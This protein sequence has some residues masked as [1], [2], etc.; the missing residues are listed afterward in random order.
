MQIT[1]Q[2]LIKVYSSSSVSQEVHAVKDVTLDIPSNSIFGIIGKSGAGKSTLVRLISLL[3]KPDKGQVL[4]DGVRVDSLEGKAL[5]QQRRRIGMIFQSFNLFSSRTAAKNVAYPLEICGV[6]GAEIKKRVAEL[7]DLVGLGDRADSPVSQLSGGQ[8]QRIAIARAL[9]NKPDILFCDEAT[10][11]LDPQTTRS[12]LDLIRQIQKKMHLTVVM[13]T[14]QMEV[15]RDACDYVAVLNEGEIA[16]QGSVEDIFTHPKTEITKD[17]LANL[18]P[19][20]QGFETKDCD[21]GIVRWSNDGGKYIFRFVGE[22]TGEPLLSKAT[23]LYGVE[24]NIRA[25][26][27][28]HISSGDVGTLIADINGDSSE[29]TAAIKYLGAQGVIVEEV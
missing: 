20:N 21:S 7:L 26:G 17:F 2:N 18:A 6:P 11:A 19:E 27:I 1:L 5:I 16:E 24:F 25:G 4:Y 8:K 13:I 10:S 9:A 28:Q 29:V 12:I 23:R 22:K 15:V 3:E 14:H